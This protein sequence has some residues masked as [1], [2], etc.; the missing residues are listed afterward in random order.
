[1][2][3]R[4][5]SFERRERERA[6]KAKANAKREQRLSRGTSP[7]DREPRADTDESAVLEQLAELHRAFEDGQITFDDLEERRGA[8]LAQLEID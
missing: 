8:L 7:G 6:K 5:E 2:A 3:R 1:M 4:N